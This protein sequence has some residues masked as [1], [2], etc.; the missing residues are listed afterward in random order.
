[1]RAFSG[2]INWGG[3]VWVL[4]QSERRLPAEAS[5]EIG[6]RESPCLP[7]PFAGECIYPA[8]AAAVIICQHQN[9]TPL[10]YQCGQTSRNL[11]D[12]STELGLP[13]IQPPG[14]SARQLLSLSS[15]Q[16][17]AVPP[18]PHPPPAPIASGNLV[19][20]PLWWIVVLSV[21]FLWSSASQSS[22][23][24]NSLMWFLM[25]CWPRN[26]KLF[27][28]ATPSLQSCCHYESWC[29]YFLETEVCQRGCNPLVENCSTREPWIRMR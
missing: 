20:P 25:Q 27:F 19:D 3:C 26:I 13:H 14:Q 23:C 12:L 15:I 9:P 29:E 2:R 22:S 7:L 28:V 6:L 16:T 24:W 17:A 8:V 4:L 18:T 11:A 10:S 1:M 21:P 5:T